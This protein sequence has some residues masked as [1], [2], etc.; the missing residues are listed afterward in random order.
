MEE[1]IIQNLLSQVSIIF[2]KY[3]E[4]AKVTGE[5]YNIFKIL[6]LTSNE[7]RTHSAF[8]ANL[9]DSKGSHD[10]GNKFLLEFLKIINPDDSTYF[11]T[12]K[13]VVKI[14]FFIGPINSTYDEGGR[15]DIVIEDDKNKRI[16]IENK[17][18]AS[19][20]YRQ[21]TR[22]FNYDKNAKLIY[23]TLDGSEP[24]KESIVGIPANKVVSIVNLSYKT[25][26]KNWLENCKRNAVNLPLLRETITQYINLIDHLTNQSTNINMSLDIKKIIAISSENFIAASMI[27]NEMNNL[28]N[29][30]N[31]DLLKRIRIEIEKKYNITMVTDEK[32][33]SN[34]WG[35]FFYFFTYNEFKFYIR[36]A[37]E[38]GMSIWLAPFK[39]DKGG[40]ADNEQIKDLKKL[41]LD[42]PKQK[43]VNNPNYTG[44]VISNFDFTKYTVA[45]KYALVN[46]KSSQEII[47][48]IVSEVADFIEHFKNRAKIDYPEIEFNLK[49]PITTN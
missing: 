48:N 36:I 2:K 7:V 12:N 44:W 20:Q 39:D 35:Y 34:K 38:S 18:F 27:A 31:E 33:F 15:I 8:I 26:I 1:I 3:E 46:E 41:L 9:L 21:L 49:N 28:L 29:N 43:V 32:S 10:C 47:G 40:V 11:D 4:I 30:L 14:E 17:I 23:L 13:Y 19:D 6:G 37:L 25:N 45:N 16:I 5:N 22:Y 42:F 24:S